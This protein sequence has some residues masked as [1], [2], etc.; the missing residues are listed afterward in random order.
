SRFT[1]DLQVVDDGTYQ[2]R[3]QSGD[4]NTAIYELQA[5]DNGVYA[6]GSNI[7][8]YEN[9]DAET[10][11]A[12]AMKSSNDTDYQNNLKAYAHTISEDAAGDWLYVKKNTVVSRK[13]ISGIVG[14]FSNERIILATL[15]K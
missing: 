3:L 15:K 8:S 6:Q 12:N 9:S 4:Y 2:Q 11:Y 13:N 1:V 14:N 10:Q 5:S 7:F